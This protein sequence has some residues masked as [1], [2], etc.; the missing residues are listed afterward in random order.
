MREYL[1]EH[2]FVDIETGDMRP[3]PESWDRNRIA[4]VLAKAGGTLNTTKKVV[5]RIRWTTRP[6][7]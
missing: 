4:D 3:V 5:K 2:H 7:S 6:R 1:D